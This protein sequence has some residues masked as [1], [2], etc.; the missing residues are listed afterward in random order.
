MVGSKCLMSL[1][2]GVTGG[3]PPPLVDLDISSV[4]ECACWTNCKYSR[5]II[6]ALRQWCSESFFVW[7]WQLLGSCYNG[8]LK[9]HIMV[10]RHRRVF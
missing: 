3:V 5:D 7:R 8:E 2:E 1:G 4:S 10:G 9:L 6:V